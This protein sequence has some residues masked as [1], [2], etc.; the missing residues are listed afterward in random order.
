MI[1]TD[2]SI[3]PFGSLA[4]VFIYISTYYDY[5]NIFWWWLIFEITHLKN[6]QIGA[7]KAID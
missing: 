3:L 6:L 4:M 5:F 1:Y 2:L 7:E